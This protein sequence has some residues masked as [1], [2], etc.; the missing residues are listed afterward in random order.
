[1]ESLVWTKNVVFYS[2]NNVD[3]FFTNLQQRSFMCIQGGLLQTFYSYGPPSGFLYYKLT[4]PN[5]QFTTLTSSWR[6][7]LVLVLVI[8]TGIQMAKRK[9]TKWH[10]DL[11][12]T[13]QKTNDISP[14][15][16]T[17]NKGWTQVFPERWAV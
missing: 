1:M 2:G 9:S 11:Q 13:T 5:W 3:I 15:N 14:M 8:F 17:K 10:N 16:S 4:S 7:A 6:R 12:N